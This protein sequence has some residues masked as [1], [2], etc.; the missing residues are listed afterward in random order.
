MTF[1]QSINFR[2]TAVYNGWQCCIRDFTNT[3]WRKAKKV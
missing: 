2:L 1:N 3:G